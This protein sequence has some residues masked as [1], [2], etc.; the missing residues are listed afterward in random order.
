[1]S[2]EERAI[3]ALGLLPS[4]TSPIDRVASVA[5]AISEAVEEEREEILI[6]VESKMR[7]SKIRSGR[8]WSKKDEQSSAILNERKRIATDIRARGKKDG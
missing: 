8:G 2:P 1:M 3:G 7:R 4:R 5:Q 6:I